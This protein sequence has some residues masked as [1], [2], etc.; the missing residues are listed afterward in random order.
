MSD[1]AQPTVT[2]KIGQNNKQPVASTKYVSAIKNNDSQLNAIHHYYIYLVVFL[3]LPNVETSSRGN[4]N[5]TLNNG[6][7]NPY[8]F[9]PGFKAKKHPQT[10]DGVYGDTNGNES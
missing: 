6:N 9:A 10:S 2:V 7:K 5:M 4:A 8:S 1:N 3:R